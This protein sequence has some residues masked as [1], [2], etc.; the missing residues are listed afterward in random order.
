MVRLGVN[1]DHVATLRQQRQGVVPDP[2]EAALTAEKYGADGIVA[3]LRE[4]PRHIQE[5][6][7]RS[8]RQALQTR[9]NL[10]M[11]ATD[12]MEAIARDIQAALGSELLALLRYEAD[13]VRL[14]VQGDGFHRVGRGHLE[15]KARL[16]R[17]AQ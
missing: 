10:E 1:I 14:N 6:D 17:L 9:L 4:D 2:V 12:A 15:I 13:A 5:R 16:E 8:L 3:H 11:A 7:I